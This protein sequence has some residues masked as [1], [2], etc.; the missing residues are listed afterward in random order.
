MTFLS[1]VRDERLFGISLGITAVGVVV[2]MRIILEHYR[3]DAEVKPTPP[4]TQFITQD[5]E[6]SLKVNTLESLLGHYNFSIRDTALKIL[7]G[8]AVNEPSAIDQFLWGIT[9]EDYE[10]RM[11]C[12]R[13]LAFAVEDKDTYQDPLSV[14]NTPKAYSAL[15]RSLELCLD[16]VPHEKLDD[17]L[18][19]EYYLRDIGERRC[20]LLVS[21]LVHKYG[22]E[23]LVEANFVEK[24]LAKQPWGDQDDERRKNFAMYMDRK[25]NRVSDIFNHLMAS[26]AG[27]KAM[28]K[29]K[30]I[31]KMKRPK[32]DRSDHIKV[33]LEI[34][35]AD[36]GEANAIQL[37]ASQSE[38]VPRVNEQ[39]AEEQRLRRR[40]REAMVLNDGTH[41]LGRGDIIEREHDANS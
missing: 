9:R 11:K 15:V 16:D 24:W 41:S 32:R 33:V 27:R 39:S 22:V 5:T 38:L 1:F 30:L 25:K 13:A 7:A 18:Y 23:K 37:E 4:K 3:D 6:D 28:M 34:S 35:M 14:L 36:D 31:L 8:R 26:K 40:H 2:A 29:A 20:L 21:Q 12:L 10:E 17:P 19:D